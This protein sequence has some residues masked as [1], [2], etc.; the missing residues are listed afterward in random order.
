MFKIKGVTRAL[1]L[2]AVLGSVQATAG[3]AALVNGGFENPHYAGGVNFAID[4]ATAGWRTTASDHKIEYWAN[5]AL[6]VAAYEGTQFVEL[7]ANMVSTLYQDVS[8]IAAGSKIGFEFAHRGRAG[9]D[10]MRLTITDLGVNNAFGGG[11]DTVLFQQSYSDGNTAWG[12]Y[13]NATALTALGH[14]VRFAYESVS[15][16]GGSTLGN[17]LDAAAFGV[18]AGNTAAVPEPTSIALSLL[19]LAG[20][21]ISRRKARKTAA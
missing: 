19:G 9:V 15:S 3:A 10:T 1:A 17:F 6:G 16:V 20:V 12:F 13:T 4:T 2:A 7:N 5:G 8:G 18:S 14:D 21:G 11:D